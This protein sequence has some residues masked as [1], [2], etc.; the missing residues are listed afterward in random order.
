MFH[1]ETK[2]LQYETICV[3]HVRPNCTPSPPEPTRCMRW[4]SS[5][6]ARSPRRQH[7]HTHWYLIKNTGHNYWQHTFITTC[8][9]CSQD[10][11]PNCAR[12]T[13]LA[14]C[15]RVRKRT[16]NQHTR[17]WRRCTGASIKIMKINKSYIPLRRPCTHAHNLWYPK[18]V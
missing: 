2:P 15:S 8:T 16:R 9:S 13:P 5:I 1:A 12:S 3:Q 11:R 6:I 17:I 18:L 10:T 7:T 14:I 4:F